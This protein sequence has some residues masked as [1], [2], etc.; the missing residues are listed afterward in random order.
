MKPIL[1]TC[2]V[3]PRDQ[4]CTGSK[5]RPTDNRYQRG[6]ANLSQVP[7]LTWKSHASGSGNLTMQTCTE[8]LPI[9]LLSVQSE[10]A[11]SSSSNIESPS[12]PW[13]GNII[14]SIQPDKTLIKQIKHWAAVIS[15]DRKQSSARWK[16]SGCCGSK[17]D[18]IGKSS[19]AWEGGLSCLQQSWQY[20]QIS[21]A[22][23]YAILHTNVRNGSM[24]KYF[25]EGSLLPPEGMWS[26]HCC[27]A[28]HCW[29]L[30]T[31]GIVDISAQVTLWHCAQ[32]TTLMSNCFICVSVKNQATPSATL[33]TTTTKATTRIRQ[34]RRI[35]ILTAGT[36]V[37]KHCHGAT[38][39]GQSP[40]LRVFKRIWGRYL[41]IKW[42][43]RTIFSLL[44]L[45]VTRNCFSK[46]IC[47]PRPPVFLCGQITISSKDHN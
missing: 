9:V 4:R 23:Q 20:I 28:V 34:R 18:L 10:R 32:V 38:S 7:R 21:S 45:N 22:L 30:C 2:C 25:E 5:L 37:S 8:F 33:T 31:C 26:Q 15:L 47:S 12:Y 36:P 42:N 19:T 41:L 6:F 16:I 29:Y 27:D 24:W 43:C 13:I 44:S 17:F 39:C 14:S 35:V 46:S 11:S 3:K 1:A 40:H